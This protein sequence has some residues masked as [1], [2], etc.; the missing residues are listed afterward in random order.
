MDRALNASQLVYSRRDSLL[1]FSFVLVLFE[2]GGI[3]FSSRYKYFWT[4]CIL[5]GEK[6]KKWL[7]AQIAGADMIFQTIRQVLQLPLQFHPLGNGN[8]NSL[9][10]QEWMKNS[11]HKR[12]S[13]NVHEVYG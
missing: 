4:L 11:Q 12:N 5:G 2:G 8:C 7:A 3:F 10:P 9:Q 1:S 6:K 13:N